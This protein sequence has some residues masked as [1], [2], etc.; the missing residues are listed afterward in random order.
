LPGE[1][2]NVEEELAACAC[3]C[4]CAERDESAESAESAD[5]DAEA[6]PDPEVIP[7]L[8]EVVIYSPV[9]ESWIFIG[10]VWL[11]RCDVGLDGEVLPGPPTPVP[12]PD[13]APRLEFDPGSA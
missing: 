13:P 8:A 7:A 9:G 10:E 12:D 2:P 11:K 6:A 4:A 5:A 1:D 3:A